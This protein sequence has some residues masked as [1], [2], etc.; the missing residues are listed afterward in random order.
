VVLQLS[1]VLNLLGRSIEKK[2]DA[3]NN[4]DGEQHSG[5]D[6]LEPKTSRFVV[7]PFAHDS[8]RYLWKYSVRGLA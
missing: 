5:H 2:S 6:L 7:G 8:R 3:A 4:Q 1:E